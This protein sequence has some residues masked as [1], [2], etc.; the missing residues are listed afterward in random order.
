MP[1]KPNVDQ[2]KKSRPKLVDLPSKFDGLTNADLT[3]LA[4]NRAKEYMR[5]DKELDGAGTG[6]ASKVSLSELYSQQ[7]KI[8]IELFDIL[9]RLN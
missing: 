9:K 6:P 7:G 1:E 5:L 4:I 3:V 2:Q 8:K